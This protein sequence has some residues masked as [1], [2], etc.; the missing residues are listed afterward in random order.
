MVGYGFLPFLLPPPCCWV[1]I[2]IIV[3]R[4]SGKTSETLSFS[5]QHLQEQP[6]RGGVTHSC[7]L[8]LE[9]GADEGVAR[10][11]MSSFLKSSLVSLDLRRCTLLADM[12][13]YTECNAVILTVQILCGR[14]HRALQGPEG[15]SNFQLQNK[16]VY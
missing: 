11:V 16:K 15:W 3:P 12:Q 4:H 13:R 8:D 1:F 5:D 7:C 2:L 9:G 6:L 10:G 14:P